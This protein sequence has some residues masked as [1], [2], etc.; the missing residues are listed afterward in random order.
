MAVAPGGGRPQQLTESAVLKGHEGAVLAA[1]FSADSNYC[2]TCG[3]DRAVRLWNPHKG[4]LIKAYLGHGREVRDVAA[5]RDNSRLAS[6]GGDRQVFLWDVS[7]GRVVRKFRGHDSDV[8][9]VKFN[10]L[11]TVAV[12]AGYDRTVRVWDCRSHSIDAIQ[13]M[14]PFSDSVTCVALTG[15]E[16]VASSVDGSVRCF[17]IRNGRLVSDFVG[18]AVV[19]VAISSDG[20]CVLASCLDSTLRLL[21]RASGELLNEY[22]GH[23]NK[24]VKLD[25]CFSHDD[26]FVVSASEDGRVLF[27]DLVEATP[28]ASLRAHAAAVTSVAY[29]RRDTCILTASAD[30]TAKVWK[31]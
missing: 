23:V 12:T 8:N 21:D 3:K 14:N 30:G 1:R 13:I 4:T 15:A 6:C 24:A 7:S 10:E 26:A 22:K 18:P 19:S 31:A 5:S 17:D 2:L 29:H 27:W 16:I 20:N 9:S 28:V 25:S 11:A